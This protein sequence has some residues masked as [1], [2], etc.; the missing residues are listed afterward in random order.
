[1]AAALVFFGPLTTVSLLVVVVVIVVAVV[2]SV[3]CF[4]KF[5]YPTAANLVN[6]VPS[7]PSACTGS[8]IM[9]LNPVGRF[10]HSQP[11]V[12]PLFLLRHLP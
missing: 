10:H 4:G 3:R 7:R 8:I 12:V 9:T 11:F 2:T 6:G 1:L 5:V